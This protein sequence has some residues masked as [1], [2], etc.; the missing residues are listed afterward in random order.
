M[1]G[2]KKRSAGSQKSLSIKFETRDYHDHFALSLINF[3]PFLRSVVN[4]EIWWFLAPWRCFCEN[5]ATPLKNGRKT[6][7]KIQF[8]EKKYKKSSTQKLNGNITQHVPNELEFSTWSIQNREDFVQIHIQHSVELGKK[9][10]INFT[11]VLMV[12]L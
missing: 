6:I 9:F 10:L 5:F 3:Y 12:P 4:F 2:H 8:D 7:N 11:I 1:T